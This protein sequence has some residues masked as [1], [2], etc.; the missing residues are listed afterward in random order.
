MI[1]VADLI[2]RKGVL[3]TSYNIPNSGLETISFQPCRELLEK[4]K[5]PCPSGYSQI[6][7]AAGLFTAT[8]LP[9][10]NWSGFMQDV[11]QGDH[12]SKS[13][14]LMLPIIYP[15]LL[16][17]IEQ[18]KKLVVTM[19]SIT[20]DQPL[21]MKALEIRTAKKTQLDIIPLLGG[22]HM[23]MS[24]YGS[25]G[26]IMDG[27]SISKLFESMYSP[28]TVKYMVTGKAVLE[29]N[30]A[31]LLTESALMMKL[32]KIAL[33]KNCGVNMSKELS[34]SIKILYK[35]ALEKKEHE[36]DLQI[37]ELSSLESF[38]DQTKSSLISRSCTTRLWLQYMDYVETGGNFI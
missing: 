25:I 28:N 34:D 9:Q 15:V 19:H 24:F 2:K 33:T 7:H 5:K 30:R 22:S 4:V 20:F 23:L 8:D 21:W 1:K 17:V 29:A 18:S 11:V 36:V 6:C 14:V 3:I 32:Q 27:S 26:T 37:P 31:H 13:D 16:F 35:S 10:Y 38:I 12:P